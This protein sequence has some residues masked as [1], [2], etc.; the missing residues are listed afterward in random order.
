[1]T[2]RFF[3]QDNEATSLR[4]IAA[5]YTAENIDAQQRKYFHTAR[6]AINEMLDDLN[7]MNLSINGVGPTNRR[8]M[9]VFVYGGLA[10]SNEEKYQTYK[11]WMGDP[12]VAVVLKATFNKILGDVCMHWHT[13][14]RSM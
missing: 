2:F 14:S 12:L 6:N 8:I 3:I 11:E 7:F 5:L 1:M 9:E 4:N 13:S 10:H